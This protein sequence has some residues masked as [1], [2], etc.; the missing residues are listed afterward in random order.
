[1]LQIKQDKNGIWFCRKD[2]YRFSL[3]CEVAAPD[4]GKFCRILRDKGMVIREVEVEGPPYIETRAYVPSDRCKACP[5]CELVRATADLLA[6][7]PPFDHANNATV[8]CWNHILYD[9]PCETWET[10]HDRIWLSVNP[11]A[12]RR[13]GFPEF[14]QTMEFPKKSM[15]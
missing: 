3:F 15:R 9:N 6:P 4:Q 8:E 14:Y 1:M 11:E 13:M 2:A 12:C 7:N 10:G 5:A